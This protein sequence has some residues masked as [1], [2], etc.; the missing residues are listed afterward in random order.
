[1]RLPKKG[2]RPERRQPPPVAGRT[3]S[4]S[5]GA[6][7]AELREMAGWPF[8]QQRLG[9]DYFKQVYG[10]EKYGVD[11]AT[12]WL[13]EHGLTSHFEAQELVHQLQA[14]DAFLFYDGVDIVNSA[15]CEVI[16]RR[17]IAIE[18]TYSSHRE[19]SSA[20]PDFF[21]LYDISK[22]SVRIPAADKTVMKQLAF[23]A[24]MA[25]LLARQAAQ[26]KGGAAM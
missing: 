20:S 24:S 8:A 22:P 11:Y 4:A 25:K 9:P 1:M 2:R 6:P 12:A 7:L 16:A 26:D 13:K 15:A 17:C 14:V 23:D 5:L 21:A 10:R 3:P 18:R 19:P